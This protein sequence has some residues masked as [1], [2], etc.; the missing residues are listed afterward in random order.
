MEEKV[1][2]REGEKVNEIEKQVELFK[3]NSQF[4]NSN[5]QVKFFISEHYCDVG[6]Y[7][8][9]IRCYSKLIIWMKGTNG[10]DMIVLRLIQTIT[11]RYDQL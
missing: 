5:K 11:F 7:W 8:I 9:R 3:G 6:F 4:E 10:D 1:R 2:Q